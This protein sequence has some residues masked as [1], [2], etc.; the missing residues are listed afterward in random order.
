MALELLALVKHD[1]PTCELLL[2]ALDSAA[3]AGAPLRV[4]SQSAP[5]ETAELVQRLSLHSPVEVDD[6]LEVSARFDPDAVPAVMLLE[7]GEERGRVEGLHL[8]RLE[9][10]F[11]RADAKLPPDGL[12]AIKPGCASRTRDPDVAARLAARRARADGR[13]TSRELELGALEDPFDALFERGLTDGLPVVPPTPERVVA[14]LEHS[15]RD[16]REVVGVVPPYDGEATVEKVAINA[17]M[18]G[19][20]PETLPIILAAVDAACEESFALHGLVATTH[21]AGPTIVVSGPLAAEA[22]MNAA[23]NCL[24]QGNRANLTIGRALQL[25]VRNVGGGKPRVEDRSAHGQMGKLGSCFAELPDGMPWEP[26]SVARGLA[27]DETGVTLMAT[28]APRLI[29]DQLAR[30]PEGLCA[31]L[32]LALESVAHPKI[33]LAFDALLLVGPEHGRVFAEAGW[34]RERVLDELFER[35]TTPASE[36]MRGAGGSPEGVDPQYVSDPQMA[37]AKFAAPDRILLAYAGGDA[38]LFSM[39]FGSWAAGEIGSAPVT[40]SVNPWL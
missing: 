25:V 35:T 20:P 11:E 31:S 14:M 6:G 4:L 40:R 32:A 27:P 9:E 16:P 37:V 36:L 30:D 17:V 12:P 2:P 38:G 26:L 34:G 33:R 10:L 22:G 7:D 39:V 19:A 15:A 21:P 5:A 3:F 28:E 8:E 23:G 24:G 13:L 18:A 29:V 1:C